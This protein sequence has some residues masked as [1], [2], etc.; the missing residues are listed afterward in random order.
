MRIGID[1]RYLSH[2][3]IGGVHAYVAFLISALIEAAPQDEFFLYADVKDEFEL[4]DLPDNVTVRLLPY[5]NK[6]SSFINDLRRLRETMAQDN[7]DIAH[8]PANYGFG[9]DNARTI[10]TLH[11]HINVMPLPEIWR[12]HPK[13]AGTLTM[14]TYLHLV[15]RRA[16]YSSDLLITDSTYSKKQILKYI[17]RD[18]DDIVVWTFGPAPDLKEVTDPDILADVRQRFNLTKPFVIADGIKN[19]GALVEAWK[20]LSPELRDRYQIVF[21]S[22]RPT[23]PDPVGEAVN[24]GYAQL[25]VRPSNEDL[26]ALY[27]MAYALAFPS[28]YEGLGLPLLEAMNFGTPV[29]AS[30]R[31]SIP[32]VVGDAGLIFHLEDPRQFADHLTRVLSDPAEHERLKQL[33]YARAT[34]FTWD[35]TADAYLGFYRQ[36]LEARTPAGV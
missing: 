25:F 30:D 34:Q 6:F 32:E 17:N 12:G 26:H 28:F 1:A 36:V 22:R 18:P 23:P 4:T 27:S 9:P 29:I 14:M 16:A 21:F 35:R 11:D 24:L 15:S 33:G 31:G 19:P 8:F 3:I 10:V 2:G 13:K 7:L 5:R 20:L